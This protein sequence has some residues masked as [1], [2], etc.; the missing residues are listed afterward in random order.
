[1]ARRRARAATVFVRP[2]A[3][4]CRGSTAR[5]RCRRSRRQCRPGSCAGDRVLRRDGADRWQDGVD[6]DAVR[7]HGDASPP[8]VDRRRARRPRRRGRRRR[9]HR[10][11]RRRRVD[12]AVR[13][14]RRAPDGRSAG[15]CRPADHAASAGGRPTTGRGRACRWCDRE[16]GC[17]SR[18]D[19]ARH[20]SRSRG[21]TGCYRGRRPRLGDARGSGGG[22]RR[23]GRA[24]RRNECRERPVAAKRGALGRASRSRGGSASLRGC[25][26]FSPDVPFRVVLTRHR[27]RGCT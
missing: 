4:V 12:G 3:P 5:R 10:P 21:R 8:R 27:R 6:P 19:R 11:E 7:V 16:H 26:R 25:E 9:H 22:D 15:I 2:V 24:G 23:S 17:R 18:V 20:G 14:L 1:M 13:L